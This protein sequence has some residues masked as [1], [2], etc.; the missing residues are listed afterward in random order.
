MRAWKPCFALL[1]TL[2]ASCATFAQDPY[3]ARPIR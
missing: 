2:A 1:F 3:P